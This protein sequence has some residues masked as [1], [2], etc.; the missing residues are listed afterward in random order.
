MRQ[1]I[2]ESLKTPVDLGQGPLFTQALFKAGNDHYYW[3]QGIHHMVMDG[4]GYALI[5]KRVAE[6]Y[7]ALLEGRDLPRQ[8]DSLEA[9]V[10]EE[11][12][13]QKSG[14]EKKDAEFWQGQLEPIDNIVCLTEEDIAINSTFIRE[15]LGLSSE[16]IAQ[17]S[18]QG[19][20][21]KASWTDLMVATI[22]A[23][24][25]RRSENRELVFGLAVMGRTGA[26]ALRTPAMMMNMVPFR[27]IIEREMSFSQLVQQVQSQFKQIRSHHH[28]RYEQLKKDLLAL[29]GHDRLFGP[30]I[31]IMPFDAE[32]RFGDL[33]ACVHKISEGPVEDLAI[34]INARGDGSHMCIDFD[35]DPACYQASTL[36]EFK[37]ELAN[38]LD[39]C[40]A[41]PSQVV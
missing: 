10:A 19:Q 29:K 11:K 38:V 35:A 26:L 20:N 5:V 12:D 27:I 1:W 39:S 2:D 28:Y 22:A 14:R 25:Y 34:G 18:H 30:L 36:G 4:Y 24:T 8:F 21:L 16:Q 17:V 15:E 3:Y 13:Y 23:W 33:P 37:Q 31:N 7:S 40:L 9:I 32:L 6:V 41:D